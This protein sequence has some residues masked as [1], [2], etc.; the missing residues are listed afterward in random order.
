MEKN[1]PIWF[2]TVEEKQ[3]FAQISQNES[4]DI[5]VIGGG[6]CGVLTAFLLSKKGK[7]VILIEKGKI[8]SGDTSFTT[9]FLTRVP[10]TECNE[11]E[12]LYG[13]DF[14]KQVFTASKH[15][16]T[17]LKNLIKD[18]KI[19]CDFSEC[20]SYY[21]NYDAQESVLSTEWQSIKNAEVEA[22]FLQKESASKI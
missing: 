21:S 13:K 18:E 2:E 10:D 11:L 7:K 19:E 20:N 6:M 1:I 4:C 17:F 14:L 16:Q 9:G 12:K 22:E 3:R 15:A 8:A 5:L